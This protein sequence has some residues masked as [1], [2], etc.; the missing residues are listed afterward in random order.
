LAK[1]VLLSLILKACTNKNSM[2]I[3]SHKL[4]NCKGRLIDLSK[5]RVMGILNVTPDSFFD[6][7]RYNNASQL[8]EQAEQL[9]SEGATFLDIGAVSSR[10]NAAEVSE[11]EEGERLIPSVQLLQKHFPEALL[12]V[13][14]FRASIARE[15]VEAGASM[16]NDISGGNLDRTMFET[17]AELQVPYIIMHM[18]GTPQTMQQA[19]SYENVALEVFDLLMQKVTTLRKLGVHDVI[20]DPGFGFGKT[21]AHNYELL[22]KLERFEDLQSPLLVGFSRKSM[23]N[24]IL[25]IKP[26]E[27]L[28]GTT[29]LNTLAL[30][31]GAN[32]LRV[33]DARPAREAIQLVQ[34]MQGTLD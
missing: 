1:R 3:P 2:S 21:V 24:R 13:D 32:I 27:A 33:H 12:S 17:I 15:A 29:V 30:E 22:Q 9:L 4:I 18:Q 28:N 19:P 6:G 26:E 5:P 25:G 7:G 10:P 20:V 8:L 14:T 11:A 16:I 31:R 23:I 34:A